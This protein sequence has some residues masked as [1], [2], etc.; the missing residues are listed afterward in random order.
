M[1]INI[2]PV[3]R[4]EAK[5]TVRTWR[6]GVLIAIYVGVLSSVAVI[7][8]GTFLKN[9][10]YGGARYEELPTLYMAIESLQL[11]LILFI[12]P[13]LSASAIS[14]ERERQTLDILL[15]TKMS[16]LSIVTGKL[17]ASLSKVVLL[18]ISTIPVFSLVF[19][20]GGVSVMH[21]FQITIFYLVTAL[22]VGGISIFISTFFKSSRVSNVVVYAVGLFLTLGTLFI[23]FIYFQ[24]INLKY[25]SIGQ[26]TLQ[27]FSAPF[28]LYLNPLWGYISLVSNQIGSGGGIPGIRTV[29]QYANTWIIN[30]IVEVIMSVILI[31]LSAWKLNPIK[32]YNKKRMSKI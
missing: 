25:V 9:M 1:K 2:N 7:T 20:F 8:F 29:S 13:S 18:I 21:I 5:T 30:C 23:T 31:F 22:Y 24:Y 11:V 32:R 12:V 15:S 16:P 6:I 4:K 3:L 19:L 14:G 17:V 10:A 26:S 28:Y 27:N